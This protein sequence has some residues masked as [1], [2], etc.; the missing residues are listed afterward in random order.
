M[1]KPK[2][3]IGTQVED[4]DSHRRGVVVFIYDDPNIACE[5]VAVRF[6]RRPGLLWVQCHRPVSA[7]RRLRRPHPLM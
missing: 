3:P 7:S 6:D 5:L 4:V 1:A 2:F